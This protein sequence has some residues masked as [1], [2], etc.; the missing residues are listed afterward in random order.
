MIKKYYSS[1]RII[2]V[3]TYYPEYYVYGNQIRPWN[4]SGNRREKI[5]DMVRLLENYFIKAQTPRGAFVIV[6]FC[7]WYPL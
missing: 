7:V 2:L 3:K 5:N 1:D 4:V 6:V